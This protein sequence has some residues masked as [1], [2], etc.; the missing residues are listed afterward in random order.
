MLHTI[1]YSTSIF[2]TKCGINNAQSE[3]ARNKHRL[4]DSKADTYASLML[5]HVCRVG[6]GTSDLGGWPWR[7]GSRLRCRTL[8]EENLT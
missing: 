5:V 2:G 6:V 3:I 1:N 8:R 4:L 7:L